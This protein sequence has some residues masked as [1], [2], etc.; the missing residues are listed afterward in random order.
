V[1][2]DNINVD[3]NHIAR[4]PILG[5]RIPLAAP[6]PTREQVTHDFTLYRGVAAAYLT[7]VSDLAVV[8]A[9]IDEV[10]PLTFHGAYVIDLKKIDAYTDALRVD[11]FTIA[12]EP[13]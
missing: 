4:L 2:A 3:S 7:P 11:G 12:V 8:R 13:E 5:G 9:A 1:T 10:S 6:L